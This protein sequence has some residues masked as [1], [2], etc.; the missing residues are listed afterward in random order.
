MTS[1]VERSKEHRIDESANECVLE[2]YHLRARLERIQ[3][4]LLRRCPTLF[5]LIDAPRLRNARKRLDECFPDIED[6]RHAL[7]HKGENEA[8]S[9]LH[10]PEGQYA[11]T[12]F[13]EADLFCT[14]YKGVFCRLQI[15]DESMQ[16]II[17]IV[18]EFF[19][20]FKSAAL[21]LEKQGHLD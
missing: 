19:D 1:A 5:P 9:E 17:E 2:L 20:G 6:F 3:S 11:I 15:S 8:F 21:E 14:P 4:V 16:K 10:A 18:S 13:E 12:R 7:A